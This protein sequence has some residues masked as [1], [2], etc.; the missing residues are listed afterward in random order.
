M[1]LLSA[2]S[3]TDVVFIHPGIETVIE[4]RLVVVVIAIIKYLTVIQSLRTRREWLVQLREE[5]AEV[6]VSGGFKHT[7]G[8]T[9]GIKTIFVHQRHRLSRFAETVLHAYPIDA[10]GVKLSEELRYC[11]SET[12]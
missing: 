7:F 4:G 3:K 9:S 10:D 2:F 12:T 5:D 11:T 1:D 6:V 8:N